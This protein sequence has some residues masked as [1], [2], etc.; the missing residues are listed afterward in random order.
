MANDVL[1][2]AQ[3]QTL[4]PAKS[5][6]FKGK[7]R[8]DA[9]VIRVAEEGGVPM[10]EGLPQY[11][12]DMLSNG[13]KVVCYKNTGVDSKYR[14]ALGALGIPMPTEQ[15]QAEKQ[16]KKVGDAITLLRELG[17]E[18]SVPTPAEPQQEQE[19]ELELP[20]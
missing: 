9:L 20:V 3:V 4:P 16:N 17:I 10:P 13:K 12:K 5:G 11:Q 15:E 1:I 2:Q 8:H 18:V 19:Q 14:Q 6:K 7:K